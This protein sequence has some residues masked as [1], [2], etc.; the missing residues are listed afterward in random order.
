MT[1]SETSK[2]CSGSKPRIFLVAATS[3]APAAEPWIL[4]VFCL[5]GAGQPMIVRSRMKVGL[6]VTARPAS[7][8]SYRAWTSSEYPVPSLVQSTWW[9]SQPYAA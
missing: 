1:S 9:T 6:S 5:F 3:S 4:P 2:V 7:I 8:A